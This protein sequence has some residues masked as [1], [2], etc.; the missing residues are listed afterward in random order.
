MVLAM[1]AACAG[2]F[3]DM[4]DQPRYEPYEPSNFFSN[5][6]SSRPLVAGTVARGELN[7]DE[8]FQ[9][10]READGKFVAAVPLPLDRKLLLRG[11]ERF[12]IYCSPCHSRTGTGD[13][14]IV[15]RGFRRPPSFHIERLRE[16][17]S[18]HFFDV[19]TKG[20]GAMPSY[21]V[22]IE[23]SDR[24]AIVAYIRALQ[25]S[26]HATMQ[27]VPQDEQERL[28][29]MPTSVDPQPQAISPEMSSEQSPPAEQPPAGE[30][31]Q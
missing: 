8:V 1:L 27:D 24:W 9:T 4:R 22:Q 23:P 6:M 11:Q 12:N 20:F 16:E 19:M 29:Q 3:N 5:D 10:G 17:P 13:G 18:G 21:A 31:P 15:Q 30:V 28:E 7:E 2:C 14:M 26:Q 25:L